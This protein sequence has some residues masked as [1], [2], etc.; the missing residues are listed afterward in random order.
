MC[1]IGNKNPKKQQL[2]KSEIAIAELVVSGIT[3]KQIADILFVT[4][5]TI[6][7]HLTTIYRIAGVKNRSSL[8]SKYYETK[9]FHARDNDFFGSDTKTDDLLPGG[10]QDAVIPEDDSSL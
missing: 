8:I 2:T 10:F 4:E 1:R 9:S 6:K 7:Y 5:K 3:N